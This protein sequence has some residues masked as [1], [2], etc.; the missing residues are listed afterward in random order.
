MDVSV[1]ILTLDE[2]ANL[3][4]CL[5]SLTWCDDIVV[6]D[7]FSTD[8]TEEIARKAGAR[9]VQRAFDDYASQRNF[10]LSEIE[11]KHPW[12]FMVDADEVVP[13][14]LEEEIERETAACDSDVSLFRM[15]NKN[16]LMGRWI[17]GEAAAIPRGSAAWR[18]SAT[19]A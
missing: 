4:S 14:D 7:S 8:G 16:F 5:R 6:L 10:G 17:R 3:G 18:A 2:E 12:V 9:F 15:R 13:P 19:C 11:Y 1:L